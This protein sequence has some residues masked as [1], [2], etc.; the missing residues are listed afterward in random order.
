MNQTYTPENINTLEEAT[1]SRQTNIWQRTLRALCSGL[2]LPLGFAPFHMPGLAILGLALLFLQLRTHTAKHAFLIGFAFAM[3][4]FGFGVSWVYVSIHNYGHLN[5]ILSALITLLFIT[6][7]ALYTGLFAISYQLLATNIPNYGRALL[8]SSLWLL[9]EYLRST[10]LGGFPW[11]SL[12]F[13]QMDSPLQHL[14]PLIG[15]LGVGWFTA[16][17]GSMLGLVFVTS[18]PKKHLMLI[19]FVLLLI[20]PTPLKYIHWTT[21]DKQPLSVGV[22]QANLSMRDKWDETLFWNLLD[23]YQN[24][25]LSLINT[26]QLVIM[27]ESAIPLPSSYVGDFLE[28]L[29]QEA[30]EKNS[31]VL[32]GIP[33]PSASDDATY[34]NALLGLGHAHGTYFKQ[35]LVPF[36]EFIPKAFSK[37]NAWLKLPTPNMARGQTHQNLITLNQHPVA[38]LIC[39][40]LA[41]PALLRAQLPEAEWILS[42]SDDGWFGHSFAIYQHLQM[43]QALSKQTGRFQIV[44][45]NGGLSSFINTEGVITNKL[46]AFSTNIL[47][48]VIHPATGATPW[49][50][51]GDFPIILLSVLIL[52]IAIGFQ[53]KLAASNK[54]RYPNQPC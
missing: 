30:N 37:P 31:A 51:T 40:E 22:I 26:K 12:G 10:S 35:H 23:Y 9:F 49:V 13:G 3:G 53:L 17:T 33:H 32:L 45:N 18:G 44:S 29:N 15:V 50:R 47:E 25:A 38:A 19:L 11:L 48:G 41:Y 8:F 5:F 6:Y 21:T 1:P 34:H 16:L 39:Y 20:A 4:F 52:L 36:G 28:T 27:P 2:L 24:A 43:A 14:L 42:I 54:R 46:P 7:L